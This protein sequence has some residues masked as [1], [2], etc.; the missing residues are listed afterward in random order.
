[1]IK[2][3]LNLAIISILSIVVAFMLTSF[4]MRMTNP[5][6]ESS[7]D[8]TIGITKQERIQ[9]N[10]LNGCGKNGLAAKTNEYLRKYKFDVVE[11]GNYPGKVDRSMVIDRLGDRSSAEKVAYA[12]GIPD[13]CIVTKIDSSLFIR[14]TVVLGNNYKSLK[15]Y[16]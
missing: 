6:V 16:N 2:K 3:Y 9:I 1:M 10:I 7:L 11:I 12:I 15:L 14:T 4:F 5:P 8:G 13:S